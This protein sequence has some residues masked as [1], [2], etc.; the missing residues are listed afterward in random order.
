VVAV[1]R[2]INSTG[3]RRIP[4]ERVSIALLPHEGSSI[5][6]AR[7]DVELS[8]LP[9][10]QSA[11][12]VLEAY[13]RMTT[14]MRFDCGTIAVPAIPDAFV[15][16]DID[17]AAPVLFRFKVV[18]RDE[19]PGRLLG[20]ADRLRPN[21]DD[22]PDTR[23]SLFP[24]ERR[25]LYS[26]IWKVDMSDG[27]TLL[28]NYNIPNL[29]A[30]IQKDPLIQGLLLPAA[31]RIVLEAIVQDPAVEDD[32]SDT[33]KARWLRFCREELKLGDDPSECEDEEAK[34][35]W[36][37]DGVRA[38]CKSYDFIAGIKERLGETS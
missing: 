31:L 20:A 37:D 29:T 30:I 13:Q 33:W 8:D 34:R 2:R 36:V 11:A 9:F 19:H 6:R 12:L 7:A 15:L 28:L 32:E 14:G 22:S 10:P 16:E 4:H 1:K 21:M 24:I 27:P 5:P 35:S 25:E 17:P 26:E 23:S 3:R 18:D 38:F